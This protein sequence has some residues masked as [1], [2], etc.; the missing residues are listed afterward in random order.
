M[1]KWMVA[2]S[3]ASLVPALAGVAATQERVTSAATVRLRAAPSLDAAVLAELPLGTMLADTG[4]SRADEGTWREV[5][6]PD[7]STGWVSVELTRPV[8]VDARLAVFEDVI[9]GRLAREGD[10][11]P[12]WF[13]L[14]DFVERTAAEVEGREDTARFA[15]YRL[16]ALKGAAWSLP[17]AYFREQPHQAWVDANAPLVRYFE[18]GGYYGLDHAAVV[19]EHDRHAGTRAADD[20]MWLAAT[21]G[22]GGECEGWVPCYLNV[23]LMLEGGYLRRYPAGRHAAEAVRRIAERTAE[24]DG[25]PYEMPP[26][27]CPELLQSAESLRRLVSAAA[28]PGRERALAALA[29]VTARC[30]A[31][32]GRLLP[33]PDLQVEPDRL[34]AGYRH[35]LR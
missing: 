8:P 24:L 25:D 2:A 15:W 19:T 33:A 12:S 32:G 13:Q 6:T 4:A 28:A 14:I 35:R 5:R 1:T 16:R 23:A 30:R 20:I 17:L 34:A 21:G 29:A 7:G 31:G 3:L 26:G 22:I 10:G 11:P 18:L 27:D 9:R